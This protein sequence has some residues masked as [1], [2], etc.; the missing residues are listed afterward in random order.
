[1]RRGRLVRSVA[2]DALYLSARYGGEPGELL[3][4][5]ARE[6]LEKAGERKPYEYRLVYCRKCKRY[7]PVGVTRS[8]RLRRGYVVLRCEVCGSISR[9]WYGG[10]AAR[11]R[12]RAHKAYARYQN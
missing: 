1:M 8:V 4:R 3:A 12:G 7:S 11:R 9:V 2:L 5:Y 10:A 6:L